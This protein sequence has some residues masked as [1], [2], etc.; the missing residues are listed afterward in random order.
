MPRSLAELPP[1][2]TSGMLTVQMSLERP[3]RASAQPSL[4]KG[5]TRSWS[6][7]STPTKLARRPANQLGFKVLLS[8]RPSLALMQHPVSQSL[9]RHLCLGEQ[10]P[11]LSH[12][13]L[14]ETPPQVQE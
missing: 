7:S 1:T 9:A 2:R 5:P 14:L 4:P 12:G 6:L 11:T 3:S 10:V 8:S 13:L